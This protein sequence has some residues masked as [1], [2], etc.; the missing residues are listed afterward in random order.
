[1]GLSEEKNWAVSKETV[2]SGEV[3]GGVGGGSKKGPH[4]ERKVGWGNGTGPQGGGS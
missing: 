1:M 3:V 4:Q 2:D